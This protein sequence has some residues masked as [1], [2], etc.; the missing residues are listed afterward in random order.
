MVKANPHL[1][2]NG[3]CHEALKFYEKCLGGKISF[4][5]TWGD[6]P[7]AKDVGPEW[8]KKIIHASFEFEGQMLTADDA[9]PKHYN[10]PQGMQV[11]LSYSDLAQAER[12]FKAL[13][14]HGQVGMPFA[15]TFWSKGFG[16]VTDQ[17]GIPWMINC[18]ELVS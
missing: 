17:F 11:L 8:S 3:H 2:F 7:A 12:V 1:H 16:M 9:P 15:K 14:E 5:M 13:S 6:S 4:S 10:K 18:S